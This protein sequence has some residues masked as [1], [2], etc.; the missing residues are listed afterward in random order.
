MANAILIVIISVIT[1]SSFFNLEIVQAAFITSSF[2]PAQQRKLTTTTRMTNNNYHNNVDNKKGPLTKLILHFDI[3]ETILVCD[4]AG[5]DTKEDSL[6]K[7]ICKN[8]FVRVPAQNNNEDEKLRDMIPTHWWDGTPLDVNGNDLTRVP[9]SLHTDWEWLPNCVPYYKTKYKKHAK[10]FTMPNQHGSIYKPLYEKLEKSLNINE[11][12]YDDDDV[13]NRNKDID[14]RISHDGGKSHYLLPSFYHTLYTLSKNNSSS[15]RLVLRTFGTDLSQVADAITAFA[16]GHH[17]D[18]PDFYDSDLILNKDEDLYRGRWRKKRMTKKDK[19]CEPRSHQEQDDDVE[20][21]KTEGKVEFHDCYEYYLFKWNDTDDTNEI[22]DEENDKIVAIGD[23]NVLSVLESNQNTKNIC[24][25]QDHYEHWAKYDCRPEAGK[26]VWV[27]NGNNKDDQ[28]RYLHI[29][30]D[31]NIHNDP[32]DSIVC[33][34]ASCQMKKEDECEF[35]TLSGKEIQ[36]LQGTHLVRVP[37][38]DAV[39]D[40]DWFLKQIDLCEKNILN[41]R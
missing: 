3:N 29:M 5:G 17:P 21:K 25:I 6:N 39:L 30:F 36:E 20:E 38:V 11:N 24:G 27:R 16:T 12:Q 31:D 8:A 15:F 32:K 4:E 13:N 26:P 2:N 35:Y 40:K 28:V 37:T 1:F 23:S 9:P 18:Y 41:E 34:R 19:I 10:Q 7:I 14:P 33:A 22:D